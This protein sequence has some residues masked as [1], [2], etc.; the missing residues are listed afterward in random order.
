MSYMNSYES[1]LVCMT[2][3]IAFCAFHHSGIS[4]NVQDIAPDYAG[5]VYGEYWIACC[6][7]ILICMF[8]I[9]FCEFLLHF[10]PLQVKLVF[11]DLYCIINSSEC[12]TFWKIPLMWRYAYLTVSSLYGTITYWIK[13]CFAFDTQ[14]WK[15]IFFFIGVLI[16]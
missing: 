5:S 11:Y 15:L 2:T 8:N 13:V 7:I 12:H 4:V 3:A 16:W 10:F 1:A 6:F 14:M 9:K